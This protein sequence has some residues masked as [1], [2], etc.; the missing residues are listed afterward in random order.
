MEIE[1]R[2]E[3]LA[4]R[5][6]H[7][8]VSSSFFDFAEAVRRMEGATACGHFPSIEDALAHR[9]FRVWTE[10]EVGRARPDIIAAVA[11]RVRAVLREGRAEIAGPA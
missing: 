4:I 10:T 7:L 8:L 3:A 1:T 5:L 11:W 9:L 6:A 2:D